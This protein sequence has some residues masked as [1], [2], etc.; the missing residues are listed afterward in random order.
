[1]LRADVVRLVRTQAVAFVAVVLVLIAVDR[2][3]QAAVVLGIALFVL[4]ATAL[5]ASFRGVVVRVVH[6]V[7]HGVGLVLTWV[8]LAPLYLLVL[9]PLTLVFRALGV[10]TMRIG[11]T[12]ATTWL[13]RSGARSRPGSGFADERRAALR[14][15]G[16]RRWGAPQVVRTV[17]AVL[18]VEVLVVGGIWAFRDRTTP[19]PELGGTSS[20]GAL[21]SPALTGQDWVPDAAAEAGAV[22]TGGTYTPFTGYSLRDHEGEHVNVRDRVRRSYEPEVPPGVEPLDVWFFGGSTMFGFDLQRDQHTIASEV[23]RLAEED[24]IYLRAR[25]YGAPGYVNFQES[26]LLAQLV[27]AGE[28]PELAVFYDGLND[29]S[30]QLLNR[31]GHFDPPGEPSQLSVDVVRGAVA[32][33]LPVS[34]QP[35]A[36]LVAS[37]SAGGLQQVADVVDDVT[38]VYGQGVELSEAMGQHGGFPVAHFWQPDLYSKSPLD[39]GEEQLLEPLALDLPRYQAMSALSLRIREALPASTV[40]LSG[41]LDDVDG[42]VLADTVHINEV[43]ARAVAEAMY[44]ELRPQLLELA[45]SS[46]P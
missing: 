19:E 12:G 6:V 16:P 35:P 21:D 13:D 18:L 25:N 39:P 11:R 42:P 33:V 38:S 9:T 43:G 1:M 32:D 14:D 27:A 41:S 44:A 4:Q 20:L 3:S 36:P 22:A 17:A 15:R 34:D 10:S 29:V 24:G 45:G 2:T 28:R 37:E 40:D 30:L 26:V 31:I 8:L 46:S 5:S 23:V 7:A